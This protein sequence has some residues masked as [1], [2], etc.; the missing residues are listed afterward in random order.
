MRLRKTWSPHRRAAA[1]QDFVGDYAVRHRSTVRIAFILLAATLLVGMLPTRAVAGAGPLVA[2]STPAAGASLTVTQS[3]VTG[4]ISH[5]TWLKN[6]RVSTQ[7]TATNKWLQG[8]GTWTPWFSTR[9]AQITSA[10]TGASTFTANIPNLT[11][12][13][14]RIK[15]TATDRWWRSHTATV[16]FVVASGDLQVQPVPE[17]APDPSPEPEPSPDP[18]PD[19]E[20]AP[21]PDP[22]PE[23][24]PAP[25]PVPLP[26]ESAAGW[27][28]YSFQA[29]YDSVISAIDRQKP[30]LV[31][32]FVEM[33]R[34]LED[35]TNPQR[36]PRAWSW[37]S[38]SSFD[39]FFQTLADNDV[40]LIV[41]LWNKDGWAKSMRAC[42]T[43]DWPKIDAFAAFVQDL[44]AK[45]ASFGI[46]AIFEAQ[47]EPDLRWGSLN[48]AHHSGATENFPN[49][50]QSGWPQGHARYTGGTGSLW[51]QMHETIN[52]PF[53]ASGMQSRYVA[54]I[55][56][57]QRLFGNY[58]N[59][60]T[61]TRWIDAT[62]PLV[63]YASFHKYGLANTTVDE[64]V[65]WVY[66]EWSIWKDRKGAAVPF[67]IG[68]IGPT[69]TGVTG[70]T[71][72]EAAEM[73]EIHAALDTDPRFEGSY[74]GMTAHLFSH[75][76]TPFPWETSLG[77]WD[78]NFDV[79]NITG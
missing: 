31:R 45:I 41:A 59:N 15:V 18:N 66:G 54:E 70:F 20:P 50:W 51:Q 53:A 40:T 7:N 64:Y 21:E 5:S 23:P 2:I 30:G 73:R 67:F 10:G 27:N 71:N 56:W 49:Q 60:V 13:S 43:C 26:A 36:P 77:W 34:F 12:G 46:N 8:N 38:G 9:S 1:M 32:W 25:N 6:V 44:E 19:P 39:G 61:S 48:A 75:N 29:N 52:A 55:T 16:S 4:T 57:I 37:A 28:V 79:S 14:Y 63:E 47:N 33:D 35:E 68:E 62:A 42:N 69:S 24:V 78:A 58:S 76:D 65:D 74:L 22:D 72:A 3:E 11:P 17:P